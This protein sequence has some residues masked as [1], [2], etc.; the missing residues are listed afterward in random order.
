M[1]ISKILLLVM[2]VASHSYNCNVMMLYTYKL[3][4]SH[5]QGTYSNHLSQFIVQ[6][7]SL[8]RLTVVSGKTKKKQHALPGIDHHCD[9]G[10]IFTD[11][12]WNN[13]Y[14]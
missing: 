6:C 9:L 2:F 4:G 7:S 3:C 8:S 10:V 13:H 12:S 5:H 11:L 1:T 14:C